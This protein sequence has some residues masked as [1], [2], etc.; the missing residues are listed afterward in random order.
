MRGLAFFCLATA[1]LYALAAMALGIYMGATHDHVLAPAHAHINLVGWVT[2]ALYGFYYHAVPAAAGSLLAKIQV[3]A[4]T[5]GVLLLGPGIALSV[6]GMTEG[7]AILGSF[8][9]IASMLLFLVVVTQ[10][11]AKAA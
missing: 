1:A 2:V 5:V 7:P 11:R 10:S 4:A 9:V 8:I 3:A 6:L